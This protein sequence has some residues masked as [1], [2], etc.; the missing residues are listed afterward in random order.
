MG[1][2]CHKYHF[3]ESLVI[4]CVTKGLL[5]TNFNIVRWVGWWVG[6]IVLSRPSADSFA[7]RRR[8]KV[9]FA[10]SNLANRT[11]DTRVT[12]QSYYDEE[13]N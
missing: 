3:Y 10:Y 12:G 8:Q 6:Q 5:V 4:K 2:T 1:H 11:V 13:D 7:V 9:H